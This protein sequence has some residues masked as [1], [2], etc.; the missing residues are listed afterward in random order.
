MTFDPD[1]AKKHMHYFHNKAR[2]WFL[3]K[4]LDNYPPQ[5]SDLV[6]EGPGIIVFHVG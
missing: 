1:P 3:N 2:M 5:V 4:R 6:F